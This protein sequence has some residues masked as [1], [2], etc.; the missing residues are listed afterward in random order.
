MVDD[1]TQDGEVIQPQTVDALMAQANEFLQDKS[2][3]Q[4]EDGHRDN[5]GAYALF[6]SFHEAFMREK[7][8]GGST[9]T[10]V[11]ARI[12]ELDM[13]NNNLFSRLALSAIAELTQKEEWTEEEI[14]NL[15][16]RVLYSA[17]RLFNFMISGVTEAPSNE[18]AFP[19]RDISGFVKALTYKAQCLFA[20]DPFS[21]DGDCARETIKRLLSDYALPLCF[22]SEGVWVNSA[23]FLLEHPSAQNFILADLVPIF[24]VRAD[25]LK[26][27]TELMEKLRTFFANEEVRLG[28]PYAFSVDESYLFAMLWP[29][30]DDCPEQIKQRALAGAANIRRRAIRTIGDEGTGLAAFWDPDWSRYY[31]LVPYVEMA[32]LREKILTLNRKDLFSKASIDFAQ[33]G[34]SELFEQVAL[35]Y[36][37]LLEDY[38]VFLGRPIEVLMDLVAKGIKIPVRLQKYLAEN[39]RDLVLPT[40]QE[41]DPV[42]AL[43][44]VGRDNFI[45]SAVKL[46]ARREYPLLPATIRNFARA[47][48]DVDLDGVKMDEMPELGANLTNNE[49]AHYFL[50]GP[51][52]DFQGVV[53]LKEGIRKLQAIGVINSE[54]A[55]ELYRTISRNFIH[56]VGDLDVD[57]IIELNANG[58]TAEILDDEPGL[59]RYNGL[60]VLRFYKLFYGD[61]Y[62]ESL[63]GF[64]RSKAGDLAK[65]VIKMDK[66]SEQRG[67]KA[68]AKISGIEAIRE[69]FSISAQIIGED[70][71]QVLFDSLLETARDGD[72]FCDVISR[73]GVLYDLGVLNG[74]EVKEGTD[75]SERFKVSKT[76]ILKFA[77]ELADFARGLTVLALR[78]AFSEDEGQSLLKRVVNQFVIDKRLVKRIDDRYDI[79]YPEM[80][81]LLRSPFKDL[82]S[83]ALFD[84]I[85]RDV[86]VDI[87]VSRS[88]T[89][90][91]KTEKMLLALISEAGDERY[92]ALLRRVRNKQNE[93]IYTK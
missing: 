71:G 56:T 55:G 1:L 62:P 15:D 85:R 24:R 84:N 82:V 86:E 12:R 70:G 44:L 53:E 46:I 27:N 26:R 23:T 58:L 33:N 40:N 19:K 59:Y 74:L 32:R 47:L 50:A 25:F 13:A 2:Q 63:S 3:A 4:D 90:L 87:L 89:D 38:H 10:F 64:F 43:K 88:E 54:T 29:T 28:G 81:V 68:G 31:S 22:I 35:T 73:I 45:N 69:Q 75:F 36:P 16:L 52:P 91:D 20:E 80:D 14:N 5:T 49:L 34:K 77:D 51:E 66:Y 48:K 60:G 11:F 78:G 30:P 7:A 79:D 93:F 9:N 41:I 76:P 57:A 6:K 18:R 61:Q 67:H 39:G 17:S 8:L 37:E 92:L 83:E 42:L 65:Q 21:E 72:W